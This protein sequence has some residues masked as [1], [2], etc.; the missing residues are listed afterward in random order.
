MTAPVE[1]PAPSSSSLLFPSLGITLVTKD[2]W[3]A[4]TGG[5]PNHTWTGLDGSI[6]L[7]EHTSPNQLRPVYVS[8]AQKGY[9]FRRTGHK[10][11]FK[12]S[13]DLIS[14]QNV[15]WDHLKDTGMDSIA[16]L[17]DPT[18]DAKMTNVIK[19]HASNKVTEKLDDSDSFPVVWLQFLK[20]IQSTSIERFEDLKAIIKARLPS[21]YSGENLEQLA[22]HFRKDANELTT[23][24]QYDH[25]LTLAM[26]KIFL[27]AG[28]SGNEDFRFPLRSVKQNLEQALLDIG[29]KD[30][31]AAN[32]HMQV[33]KLTYK[34]ICAHA[35]DAY[36][37][38]FDRKEW[39]PARHTR[40]SRLHQLHSE[41]WRLQSPEL[42]YSTSS[43]Q[44]LQQWCWTCQE[45]SLSQVQQAWT[46][47]ARM[48]REQQGQG[49]EWEWQ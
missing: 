17:R 6:A 4:W 28:G 25:N 13:D 39:P 19:A 30:K 18:D 46:L 3:S 48:P 14:F 8:A 27:L 2:E 12:P 16:Y 22:A 34:D 5:K 15:V 26:L 11:S 1:L 23:A 20:S 29:F 24:G 10:I 41:T 43:V 40:D 49:Q 33:N 47:V 31:E 44:G 32:L 21:Q 37:T 35:E 7:L 45:R 9:N 38:L 42:R 36:R